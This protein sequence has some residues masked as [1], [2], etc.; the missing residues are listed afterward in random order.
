[1]REIDWDFIYSTLT[2]VEKLN[3]D[4]QE[5]L[6][7]NVRLLQFY[8]GEHISNKDNNCSGLLIIKE[9]SIR[10][11]IISEEGREVTLYRLEKQDVCVMSASCVINS[12]SFDIHIEAEV[13][14]EVY[15]IPQSIVNKLSNNVYVENFLLKETTE[16]FSDVMWTMELILFYKLDKRLAMF[17]L[18]EMN[19]YNN[20]TLSMTHDEIAKY[21]G[22]AREVISKM[23]KKFANEG[24]VE[25]TRGQITV[26]DKD[27]LMKLI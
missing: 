9:G 20:H 7:N 24:I 25:L 2:F 15:I 11:Y 3:P 19:R 5:L 12:I 27:A 14:S 23:L 16:R 1:M 6:R 26:I 18:D 21:L 22:T 17:I 4:E 10:T 8:K 13:D